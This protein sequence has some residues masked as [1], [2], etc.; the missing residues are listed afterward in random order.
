MEEKNKIITYLFFLLLGVAW[1]I[2]KPLVVLIL[3]GFFIKYLIESHVDVF[4]L[5]NINPKTYEHP[6]DLL[7]CKICKY[8]FHKNNFQKHVL[9]S[10]FKEQEVINEMPFLSFML[11]KNRHKNYYTESIKQVIE[12][13]GKI[14]DSDEFIDKIKEEK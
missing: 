7:K 5:N 2:W 9:K 4:F 13:G 11:A 12:I 6:E 8:Y 10:S 3:V 1:L 14:D